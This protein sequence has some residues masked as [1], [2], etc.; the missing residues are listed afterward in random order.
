MAQKKI[1]KKVKRQARKIKKQLEPHNL[2]Q[3]LDP[4][5]I[6]VIKFF[7]FLYI[8]GL[9]F[10]LLMLFTTQR[11]RQL[12]VFKG[13]PHFLGAVAIIF[14]VYSVIELKSMLGSW[15]K[16]CRKLA[17]FTLIPGILGVLFAIF[18]ETLFLI[19]SPIAAIYIR[20]V[21]PKV[22]V[23]TIAYVT[24]GIGFYVFSKKLK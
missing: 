16:V 11:P 9:T 17:V 13:T 4:Q 10:L 6:V 12:A 14:I 21:I 22:W 8:A 15:K 20:E 18:G 1:R 24:I 19:R 7:K 2:K 23:L 5:R 3:R